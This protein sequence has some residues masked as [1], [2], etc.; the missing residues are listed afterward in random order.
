MNSTPTKAAQEMLRIL[1]EHTRF[2]HFYSA[3]SESVPLLLNPRDLISAKVYSAEAVKQLREHFVT[4]APYVIGKLGV[5][6]HEQDTTDYLYTRR[7]KDWEYSKDVQ[8]VPTLILNFASAR[9]PGGNVRG[10]GRG[11]EES[12]CENSTL[13][14]SLESEAAEE[15]YRIQRSAPDSFRSDAMLLSPYVE[16][17][18]A[19]GMQRTKQRGDAADEEQKN[20]GCLRFAF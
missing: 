7:M 1:K 8:R 5:N 4:S 11:Q 20:D 17:F 6:F 10:G 16:F 3:P 9:R 12:L 18:G 19:D 13:L 14:A 15:F 2:P